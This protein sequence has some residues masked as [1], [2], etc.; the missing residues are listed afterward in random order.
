MHILELMNVT[1]ESLDELT[2]RVQQK[3]VGGK[4]ESFVVKNS[5]ACLQRIKKFFEKKNLELNFEDGI[6]AQNKEV[7]INIRK[8]N[9][10]PVIRLST[11]AISYDLLNEFLEEIKKEIW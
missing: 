3:W 6:S 8:S 1:N 4:E 9:T 2:A 11:H 7:Y 10:Q 5:D